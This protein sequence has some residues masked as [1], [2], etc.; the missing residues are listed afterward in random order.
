[1]TFAS[2]GLKDE[3]QNAVVRQNFGAPFPIQN[4]AIPAIL[5]GRDLL[6]IARSGSGKTAGFVLPLLQLIHTPETGKRR[7]L[8]ALIVVPTRELAA[9]IFEVVQQLGIHLIPKVKTTAVFGGVAINP[10]MVKLNGI[11][12]LIATPGRLLDLLA[13]NSLTLSTV[14]VLILDEA[15]KLLEQGFQDELKQ[16][17][18]QLPKKRQNLLF[19]AT[20]GEEVQLL[21]LDLLHNP[22]QIVIQEDESTPRSITQEIYSVDQ[23]RKGPLL[24]YLIRSNDWRQVLVFT[25]SQK[26]ADAIVKK[27]RSQGLSAATFHGGMS[28]GA[29]TTAL[30]AFKT[31]EVR[32][33]AATDLAARGID[34]A[35]L[36][37]VVNYELPRSPADFIHRI[38]RTGR[39]KTTGVAISFISPEEIPHFKIIE[40]L[41]GERLTRIDTNHLDLADY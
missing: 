38:G 9:Q 24:R 31:G 19:S 36:P 40:K 6:A 4:Q 7:N 20:F 8:R 30:A 22:L 26:R 21:A 1:M 18:A 3:L 2:L 5:Q 27:L 12:L 17:L 23:S 25:A 33:L 41:W 29:R 35:C 10:Q 14:A 16:I 13:R 39:A 34:I 11:E 28:Q 15:D 32:V 37:H